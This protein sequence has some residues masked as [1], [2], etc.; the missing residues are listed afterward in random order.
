MGNKQS[1]S[2]KI[3]R[4]IAQREN[5]KVVVDLFCG[6]FSISQIF[7]ENGWKVYSNDKNKYVVAL[8]REILFGDKMKPIF[9]KPKFITRDEFFKV[10]ADDSDSPDWYKGYVMCVWSFGNAQT[11]YLFGKDVVVIKKAGHELVINKT[12]NTEIIPL[13]EETQAKIITLNDWHKRRIALR[14]YGTQAGNA[15]KF[16]ELQQLQQLQQLQR[17]ERLQQLEQLERLERLSDLDYQ[18]VEIPKDAVIYCDPPYAGTAEYKEGGFDNRAFWEWANKISKTHKV[19]VSEYNA[20]AG[21]DYILSIPKRSTLAKSANQKNEK[22]FIW[23]GVDDD[24]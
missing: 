20:P 6:G 17:L 19:Y 10:I 13:S 14:K 11:N 16:N 21:W 23:K 1:I 9:D 2:G 3:Y 24:E 18:D 8:I 15:R 5:N 12:I 22:L 7:I 4:A